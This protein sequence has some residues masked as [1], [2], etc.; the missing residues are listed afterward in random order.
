MRRGA[1]QQR[2]RQCRDPDL[3]CP[4][5]QQGAGAGRGGGSA[6]QDVIDQ[7]ERAAAKQGSAA[8]IHGEGAADV[9]EPFH[10]AEARLRERRGSAQQGPFHHGEAQ[11][12]RDPL[13]Q[14]GGVV[15]TAL[16]Q[17]TGMQGNGEDDFRTRQRWGSQDKLGQQRAK[18]RTKFLPP[19]EFEPVDRRPQSSPVESCGAR[20]RVWRLLY[21]ASTAV[22][23][24]RRPERNAAATAEGRARDD[25]LPPAGRAEEI[26]APPPADPAARGKEYIGEQG[27]HILVIGIGIWLCPRP[28][29]TP[30]S[31]VSSN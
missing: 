22:A 2:S 16:A 10:P 13:R 28:D 19:L 29:E 24:I 26:M 9:G 17:P 30:R 15:E 11:P 20:D 21:P 8:G 4:G 6:R 25:D 18:D 1:I 3:G 12:R 23:G 31:T 5:G 27:E 7:Q 14:Q